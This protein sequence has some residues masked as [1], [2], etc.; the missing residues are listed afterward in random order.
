MPGDFLNPVDNSKLTPEFNGQGTPAATDSEGTQTNPIPA[1]T[2]GAPQDGQAQGV[3]GAGEG[4]QI[5][6][7]HFDNVE[8]II[9]AYT[10]TREAADQLQKNYKNLQ[11]DYTKKSQRLSMLN[12]MG[13]PNVNNYPNAVPN[14]NQGMFN[15][16][17][18]NNNVIPDFNSY[19]Y[20]RNIQQ[21]I[22]QQIPPQPVRQATVDPSV[23]QMATDQKI[24]E[25]RLQDQDFDDVAPI[26]WDIIEQDPYF[27]NVKFTDVE[28]TKNTINLAYQMAK[29]KLNQA[30]ANI[31]INNAR[32]EA[33]VNKQQKVVNNDNSSVAGGGVA[34]KRQTKQTDAEIIKSSIL[35]AKPQR[36]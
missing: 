10:D 28:M 6:E 14:Y 2:D 24:A 11:S 16:Y 18:Q 9:K 21:P 7:E 3:E 34:Q 30:K 17:Q 12:K 31:N 36:F 20:G 26:L 1:N 29:D 5:G 13:T 27:S 23:I 15:P 8:D 22:G 35:G 33:Y 4:Y 25:L 32:R 19:M